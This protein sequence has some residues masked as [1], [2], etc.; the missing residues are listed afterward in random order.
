MGL[1]V[2]VEGAWTKAGSQKRGD[3]VGDLIDEPRTEGGEFVAKRTTLDQT[4]CGV[5]SRAGV[6]PEGNGLEG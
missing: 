4:E 3:R 2:C 1:H 6:T 5:A